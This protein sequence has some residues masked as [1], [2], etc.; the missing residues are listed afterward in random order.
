MEPDT[1]PKRDPKVRRQF[2]TW[3]LGFTALMLL[4]G[5]F[6]GNAESSLWWFVPAV[7][8]LAVMVVVARW[9]KKRELI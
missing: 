7:A 3:F 5:W 4:M 1:R 8:V 2:W 6:A 9:A